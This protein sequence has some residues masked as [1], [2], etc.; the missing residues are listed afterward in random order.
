MLQQTPASAYGQR[1]SFMMQTRLLIKRPEWRHEG[2][3]N[4]TKIVKN[5]SLKWWKYVKL[6]DYLPLFSQITDELLKISS[7]YD[8]NHSSEQLF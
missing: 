3:F 5:R 1:I 2:T 7:Q 6:W 8:F 4:S